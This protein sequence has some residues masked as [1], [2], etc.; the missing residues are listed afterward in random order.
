MTALWFDG[1]RSNMTDGRCSPHSL[2]TTIQHDA[3]RGARLQVDAELG[4]QDVL[5]PPAFN[6]F[7]C[8]APMTRTIPQRRSHGLTM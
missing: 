5:L 7:A 4:R 8:T 3:E 1:C 2:R 6:G